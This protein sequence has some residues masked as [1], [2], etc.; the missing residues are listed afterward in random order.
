MK[1]GSVGRIGIYIG[2]GTY[3]NSG[4][5]VSLLVGGATGAGLIVVVDDGDIHSLTAVA[6]VAAEV[7]YAI[8]AQIHT[9][10]KLCGG[11]RA[12]ARGTAAMVGNKIM[13]E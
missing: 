12:K 2:I 7:I 13:M 6:S 1:C 9:L 8:V 3:S 4:N 11:T 5:A 10:V